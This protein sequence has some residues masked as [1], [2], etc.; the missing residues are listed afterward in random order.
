MVGSK[1]FIRM[2]CVAL[3][4]GSRSLWAQPASNPEAQAAELRARIEATPI[5][6]FKKMELLVKLPATQ[7]LGMISWLAYDPRHAALWLIQRGN[8]AD[9]IIEVDMQGR[10]LCSFGRGLFKIPHSIRLDPHGNLWTVDAG[11]SRVIKFSPKGE[12]LLHFD[13]PQPVQAS[14]N[15][16]SGATDI[17]FAPNGRILI[18]DGYVNARVLVYTAQG[19]RIA[20]WGTA[21]S[22]AGQLHLPHAILVEKGNIVYIA[23]RENGRIE[24]FDLDGRYL[25]EIDGLG[26]VYSLAFG[27][28]G[29]LWA[30][31]APL[32]VPPGSP[33]WIL[34]MDR[35]TGR[36]LGHVSV[37]AEPGLHCLD[38]V[39]ADQPLISIGNEVLWFTG[40]P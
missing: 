23:D 4:I 10:L 39:N 28:R 6:Q 7:E 11:S 21:G 34:K 3:W 22:G 31:T 15:S 33:G 37:S 19:K 38:M 25:G 16:F 29:T 1:L 35:K 30:T 17:T 36:I 20:E 24:K 14:D 2:V 13:L 18:S 9:P 26:R 27:E 40:V 32:N 12:E 5:L 8:K